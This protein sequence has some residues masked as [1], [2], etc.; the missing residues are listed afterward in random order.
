MSYA[1]K[2]ANRVFGRT[3][4]Q[5]FAKTTTEVTNTGT[6]TI[7]AVT[8]PSAG[9]FTKLVATNDVLMDLHVQAYVDRNNLSALVGSVVTLEYSENSGGSWTAVDV[10]G[11]MPSCVAMGCDGSDVTP[12]HARNLHIVKLFT[13]LTATTFR[14]RL[15]TAGSHAAPNPTYTVLPSV[16]FGTAHSEGTDLVDRFSSTCLFTELTEVPT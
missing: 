4:S 10:T 1:S 5:S 12:A 11:N 14:V 8:Y 15:K 3:R 13:G 6:S 9:D 7:V 2:Q 16:P